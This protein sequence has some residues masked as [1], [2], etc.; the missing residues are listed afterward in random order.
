MN[1]DPK[2]KQKEQ[3]FKKRRTILGSICF[4]IILLHS[5]LS[6]FLDKVFQQT[7][8]Q[9]QQSSLT[10]LLFILCIGALLRYHQAV[11]S[12][13]AWSKVVNAFTAYKRSELG[14][15]NIL[16]DE[17]R[18]GESEYEDEDWHYMD[19]A[20]YKYILQE[21]IYFKTIDIRPYDDFHPLTGLQRF[22]LRCI[23]GYSKL[24]A[25]IKFSVHE[26]EILDIIWPYI[27]ALI[28]L[29]EITNLIK[30][31]SL[32]RDFGQKLGN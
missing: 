23:V 18:E 10:A 22:K 1:N 11:R 3:L 27:F 29:L 32:L 13:A 8:S 2:D 20:N 26:H 21:D 17:T 6:I 15:K 28:A 14:A 9:D 25:L 16:L 12:S 24:K 19:E 30:F 5:Q 7:L 4:L 31:T